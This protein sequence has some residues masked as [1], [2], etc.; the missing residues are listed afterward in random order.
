[1]A[2]AG[3]ENQYIYYYVNDKGQLNKILYQRRE[4]QRPL[5]FCQLK[6]LVELKKF[7]HD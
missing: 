1:M 6:S 5:P 3:A 7:G 4:E 2:A